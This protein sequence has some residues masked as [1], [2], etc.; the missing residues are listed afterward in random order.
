[1]KILITVEFYYPSVGGSQ[2]VVK[3]IAEGLVKKG[4]EVTVATSKMKSRQATKINGVEIEEFSIVGNAVRGMKGEIQRYQEY[5]LDSSFDLVFNYAAQQWTTDIVLP[6]LEKIKSK[7]VLA[8]CG[9]SGLYKP[10]FE[11][12]YSSLPEYLN[13]YNLLIF[14]SN[15][16]RDVQYARRHSLDRYVIIPNGAS[17]DEFSKPSLDF[18]KKYNI[19]ENVPLFLTVGSHTGMKGHVFVIHVIQKLNM[20]N[21]TLTVIGNPVKSVGCY[22]KCILSAY[23]TRMASQFRKR[24]LV[25]NPP[26]DD[27]IGAYH[28]ADVFL[29]A[30]KIECSPLVLFEALASRTPFISLSCGNAQEIVNWSKGGLIA[31]TYQDKM[32]YVYGDLPSFKRMTEDLWN[33]YEQRKQ[34]AE[35]GYLAWRDQFT[36]EKICD[37]YENVFNSLL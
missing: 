7:K 20:E 27:V 1:M 35:Q 15:E 28:A 5:L 26:R 24:V 36:W 14:H 4:H 25:I 30:S 18:R 21:V 10:A 23:Y 22:P 32:G 8:P 13:K 19:E 33:D 9:F 34:M 37:Q 12:Y 17:W 2:E 16:Y 29:F 31:P 6:V 3:Q 11:V